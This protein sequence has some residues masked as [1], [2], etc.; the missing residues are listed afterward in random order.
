M[1][2]PNELALKPNASACRSGACSSHKVIS[3]NGDIFRYI[4]KFLRVSRVLIISKFLYQL[5]FLVIVVPSG[6]YVI[7]VYQSIL[8][9]MSVSIEFFH[10]RHFSKN[11]AISFLDKSFERY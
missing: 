4:N 3:T 6:S 5:D 9:K 1:Q 8:M 10:N 11:R 2:R 7:Q